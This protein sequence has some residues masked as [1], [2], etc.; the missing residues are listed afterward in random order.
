MVI[1]GNQ[2]GTLLTSKHRLEGVLQAIAG[3]S[4]QQPYPSVNPSSH[5]ANMAGKMCPCGVRVA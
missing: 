1:H 4:H 2:A 3:E 5:I